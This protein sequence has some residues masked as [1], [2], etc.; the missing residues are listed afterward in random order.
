MKLKEM[1]L[2]QRFI[3]GEKSL[4]SKL[5]KIHSNLKNTD[6]EF[7]AAY[8]RAFFSDDANAALTAKQEIQKSMKSNHKPS[9]KKRGKDA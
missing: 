7:E 8:L 2:V 5:E 9:F 3:D 4:F 1:Q 6:R